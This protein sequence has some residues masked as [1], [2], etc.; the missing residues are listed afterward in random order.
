MRE[1]DNVSSPGLRP[2]PESSRLERSPYRV[3]LT[4][5]LLMAG[6]VA[7]LLAL[8]VPSAELAAASAATSDSTDQGF[9]VVGARV[10]DGEKT[11]PKADVWVRDGHIEA[12]GESLELPEGVTLCSL[13][14][15]RKPSRRRS[16]RLTRAAT[17]SSCVT[18]MIVLPTRISS[19][20]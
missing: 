6:F 20:C 4:M 8:P 7:V 16:T 3:L 9:A 15:C 1:R 2:I 11:W 10:F 5:G 18:K 12:I 17:S 14:D 19:L 13:S